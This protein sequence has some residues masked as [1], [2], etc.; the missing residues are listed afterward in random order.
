M[1]LMRDD[2][3]SVQARLG[4][5]GEREARR[6][7]IFEE[8]HDKLVQLGD[9]GITK[10]KDALIFVRNLKFKKVGGQQLDCN[11]MFCDKSI[12]S[13]GATRV[14]DHFCSTCVLVPKEVKDPFVALLQDT[15]VARQEKK[16]SKALVQVEHEVELRAV[17][18]QK[19]ELRQTSVR[20]GFR[21]AEATIADRAI[22]KFF[23]ANAV[24]FGTADTEP[25]SYYQEMVRAIQ[26]AGPGYTPPN[27]KKIGGKMIDDCASE[28]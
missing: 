26:N 11:C 5:D 20:E 14:V 21:S 4:D 3:A 2:S 12:S 9:K 17:K 23:Y 24:S 28:M 27:A 16:D 15:A 7:A 22:S 1:A 25:G 10:P 13:T 6:A 19:V 18:A 8:V